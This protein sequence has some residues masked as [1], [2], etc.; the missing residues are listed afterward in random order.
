MR[1]AGAFLILVV[2][3]SGC[4]HVFRVAT[5]SGVS[6]DTPIVTQ[7]RIVSETPP[8]SDGGPVVQM[9]LG[10]RCTGKEPKVAVLDVDGL[11]L[12]IDMTGLY[13]LGENPVSVFREKLDAVGAD[14][15][16]CAVV[17]R[18]NSPGGGVT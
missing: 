3:L 13:S 17:V 18:I 15:C 8:V 10:G 9:P 1:Y 2:G 12:N 6:M 4:H 7:S 14:P 11:L 5:Q 16:V